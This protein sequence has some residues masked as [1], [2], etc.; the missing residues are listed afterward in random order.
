MIK[1]KHSKFKNTAMIFELLTRQITVDVLENKKSDALRI[2]K[3]F[4]NKQAILNEELILYNLLNKKDCKSETKAN[5]YIDSI[6][7]SRLKINE[8]ELRKE[9]YNLIKEIK[10]CYSISD[11]FNT[12][13]DN[14]KL[15]ASVYKLFESVVSTK[16]N[17]NPTDAVQSRYV[18][19]E[20]M[21]SP[22][23]YRNTQN[24]NVIVGMY[25]KQDKEIRM[26]SYK[27]LVEKFNERY[28]KLDVNQRALL[29]KYI[30]NLSNTNQLREY[31]NNEIPK[32]KSIIGKY[33]NRIDDKVTQI[34]LNEICNQV[35][36]LKK[37]KVVKDKQMITVLKLYELIR[38]TKSI[39]NKN[40][41]RLYKVI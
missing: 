28:G 12:K 3:K 36:E 23:K 14:Y 15:M 38:E 30:D 7:T 40:T 33:A 24:T 5:Y 6:T 13:L 19:I 20:N 35:D 32:I 16:K 22:L 17:Y 2:I 8:S 31:I 41:P 27:L 1:L 18:I 25:K 4:F 11:F 9:K 10:A 37:G 34:K 29:K 21:T 39:I 26:L